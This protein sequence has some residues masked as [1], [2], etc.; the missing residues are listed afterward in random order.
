VHLKKRKKKA[1]TSPVSGLSTTMQIAG[2]SLRPFAP[3]RPYSLVI[4]DACGS[5]DGSSNEMR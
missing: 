3:G 1:S 2:A 4:H 5:S